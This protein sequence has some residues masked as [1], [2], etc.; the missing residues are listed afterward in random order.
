MSQLHIS[1]GKKIIFFSEMT[2]CQIIPPFLPLSV[3]H[4]QD[5]LIYLE[6]EEEE[7]RVFY[8]DYGAVQTSRLS[9]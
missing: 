1:F 7:K 8:T 4:S 3:Q 5:R 2:K 9:Q 6:Q